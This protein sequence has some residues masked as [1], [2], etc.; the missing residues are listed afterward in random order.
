MAWYARLTLERGGGLVVVNFL[1]Q[2][3]TSGVLVRL[4]VNKFSY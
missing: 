3:Y 4:A 1:F 2:Y